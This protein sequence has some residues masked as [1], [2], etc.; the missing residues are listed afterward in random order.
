[1]VKSKKFLTIQK[2][3]YGT[4]KTVTDR[5]PAQHE[6]HT[7]CLN[8]LSCILTISL[9]FDT[10]LIRYVQGNVKIRL[11]KVEDT[12]F[13]DGSCFDCLPDKRLPFATECV[14]EQ[15]LRVSANHPRKNTQKAT[16][17]VWHNIAV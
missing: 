2:A 3:F 15:R 13:Q 10:P 12:S 16:L 6:S 1:M 5:Q 7:G 8:R 11:E 14:Y 17:V 4:A 9:T